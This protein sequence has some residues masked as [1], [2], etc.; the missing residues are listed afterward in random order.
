M[1]K[2]L[3]LNEAGRISGTITR[4]GEPVKEGE[5]DLNL[6]IGDPENPKK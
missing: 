2:P 6:S 5:I 4:Y 3:V 1:E